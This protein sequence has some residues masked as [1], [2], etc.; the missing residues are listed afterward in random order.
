[1]IRILFNLMA[2]GVYT[3]DVWM[4]GEAIQRNAPAWA[5]LFAALAGL[6]GVLVVLR[7]QD[8]RP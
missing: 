1:M 2:L 6:M 7:M 5:A 4:V 8:G 3:M